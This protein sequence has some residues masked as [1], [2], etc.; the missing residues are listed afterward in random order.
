MGVVMRKKLE[1]RVLS[2]LATE[3]E[4]R[5]EAGLAMDHRYM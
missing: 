5:R 2:G 4:D 3:I 1:L